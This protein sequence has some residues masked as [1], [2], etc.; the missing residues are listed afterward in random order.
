MADTDAS[1]QLEEAPSFG[2][3]DLGR[4]QGILFGDHARRT[5][6]RIDTLEAAL[7]GVIAD[8]R[9]HVEAEF[10]AL[11]KR[12]DVESEMRATAVANVGE[13][14]S[15]E[16]RMREQQSAVLRKD[17]D[18]SHENLSEALDALEQRSHSSLE[19]ARGELGAEIEATSQRVS[20][21]SVARADLASALRK[22]ADDLSD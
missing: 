13:R 6:E 5:S 12:L 1:K 17:L 16:G 20:D 14:L 7:L 15:E 11:N 18:S 10:V 3:D 22:V 21:L 19:T 4:I 8:L 9:T 2:D